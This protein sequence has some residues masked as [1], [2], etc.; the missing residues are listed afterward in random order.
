MSDQFTEALDKTEEAQETYANQLGI[1]PERIPFT[2]ETLPDASIAV[3]A[4]Q[5]LLNEVASHILNRAGHIS[6]I[7]ERGAGKS[8]FRDLVYDA[9]SDGPRSEE[10]RVARIREVESITTRRFYTRLL[11]ELSE[12]DDLEIP[13]SYPH[14]TDE[15]RQIVE[16]VADQLEALDI[17]CI[18]Q[19]DQLEDAA[20][21]TRTFEQ[22]LAAL[23]S[24]GDLGES[25]P[26]FILFLFGTE[27][28]GN[29]IDELRETFSSRLVA[30]DRTLERFGFAETEELI[31]RWLAWAREEE[32]DSG[33]PSDPY[34]ASAIET[35]VE[36]S[37]GTPRNTRQKCYHAFRAGAQ[38]FA[39]EQDVQITDETLDEYL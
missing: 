4:N 29:R 33:Y 7:D 17:A 2:A 16:E 27:R 35:V 15:V 5:D 18:I 3:R 20:R 21:N 8:H 28:A 39:A 37:D 6:I 36:V 34:T 14:A 22:L 13:E 26:V 30:K 12:Y 1:K 11:D 31:A 32:Y 24:V 10:F 9:L 38:Q 23:Q 19:V 25:E